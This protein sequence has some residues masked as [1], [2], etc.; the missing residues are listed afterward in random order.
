MQ[1]PREIILRLRLIRQSRRCRAGA[2]VRPAGAG[3]PRQRAGPRVRSAAT[4]ASSGSN[5]NSGARPQGPRGPGST[6]YICT[7][8]ERRERPHM[9]QTGSSAAV[10]AGSW[11]C[12]VV[13]RASVNSASL[14]RWLAGGPVTESDLGLRAAAPDV[15]AGALTVP[16]GV[17]SRVSGRTLALTRC[18]DQPRCLLSCASLTQQ[19]SRAVQHRHERDADRTTEIRAQV[20]AELVS[21][22][23]AGPAPMS[24]TAAAAI[25]SPAC[26]AAVLARAARPLQGMALRFPAVDPAPMCYLAG[27]I[28]PPGCLR[29]R[30]PVAARRHSARVACLRSR[31]PVAGRRRSATCTAAPSRPR[32]PGVRDPCD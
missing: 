15:G 19:T 6:A 10:T 13:S 32:T 11:P 21:P 3:R 5:A 8:S 22:A 9:P 17:G 30:S 14:W 16:T 28:S 29:S 20:L 25:C 12:Q 4:R 26:P 24:R 1:L 18:S 7:A 31:S 2:V 27:E 23:A